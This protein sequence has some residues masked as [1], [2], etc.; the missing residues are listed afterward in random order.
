MGYRMAIDSRDYHIADLR[1]TQ[2]VAERVDN[3]CD[4][5]GFNIELTNVF[6][7][8][9]HL[10][11]GKYTSPDVKAY[12]VSPEKSSVTAHFCLL[13][14][15]VTEGNDNL[16]LQ[17]GEC[18][19]F[20]ED[21]D[22]YLYQMG[23]D[24]RAGSFFEMSMEPEVYAELFQGENEIL[25]AVLGG[26]YL[27]ARLAQDYRFY[28]IISEM[29]NSKLNYS[30]MLK[31]FYL[32]SKTMELFLLQFS[33]LENSRKEVAVKLQ[34]NDIEAIYHV[35]DL[36]ENSMEHVSI[37]QLAL[38]VG[39]NQTKLKYGFKSLFGKTIFE[40]LTSVRMRKACELLKSTDMPISYIAE[41]VGYK[42]AQHFTVAF[43]K[44]FGFSP[45]GLR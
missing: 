17:R 32:E 24:A 42:H 9:V 28:I 40:Y 22:E 35:R 7:D 39:I 4:D 25:D 6:L 20:R 13:G 1:G 14:S 11:W 45:S 2:H 30:G 29:Y 10:K 15:C 16:N 12:V 23:T 18:L 19:L 26:K 36:L 43:Q 33:Y 3:L 21:K 37:P 34:D 27:F 38:S 44:T 31:K 8:N 5:K 41:I